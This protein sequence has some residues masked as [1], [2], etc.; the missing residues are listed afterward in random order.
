MKVQVP[1]WNHHRW[2]GFN[3][4]SLWILGF[5]SDTHFWYHREIPINPYYLIL[6]RT[7]PSLWV[8]TRGC[9]HVVMSL[10]G[11][12]SPREWMAKSCTYLQS[13]FGVSNV[14]VSHSVTLSPALLLDSHVVAPGDNV[15]NKEVR[16]GAA[17]PHS[18]HHS[19]STPMLAFITMDSPMAISQSPRTAQEIPPLLLDSPQ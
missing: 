11:M 4:R 6:E 16:S 15:Q 7:Y 18:P 9:G 12:I 10:L 5:Y 14:P 2:V 3:R 17:V 19:T 1:T 13:L 8:V